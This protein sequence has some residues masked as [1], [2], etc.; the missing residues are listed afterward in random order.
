M[1]SHEIYPWVL[2]KLVEKFLS[3]SNLSEQSWQSGKVSSD[4]KRGNLTPF[5]KREKR[6]TWGTTVQSVS[7]L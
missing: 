1:V 5:L 4:W 2:R 6:K 7:D 3:H